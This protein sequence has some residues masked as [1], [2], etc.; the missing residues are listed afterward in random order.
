MKVSRLHIALALIVAA[1]TLFLTVS[2][3]LAHDRVEIGP[4]V[5][6]I[7]W[8]K[9]PVIVGERNALY[10][11]V[12][13]DEAPVEG[14]D[15]DVTVNYAGETFSG[16]L[17]PAAT[18]GAY[19]MELLPTVRGQY[20]VLLSGAIGDNQVNEILEP[21]E[22][23]PARALQFPQFAPDALELQATIDDLAGQLQTARLVTYAALFIAL[24][25]VIIAVFALVRSRE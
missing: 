6:V 15:L 17:S 25:A 13:E 23:L 22:V 20:Q 24:A 1:A 4:Y 9:E 21:E 5:I 11:E 10:F 3:A 14:L 19:T 16:N 2:P 12:T 7:G 18:P 8:E